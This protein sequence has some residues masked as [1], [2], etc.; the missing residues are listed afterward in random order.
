MQPLTVS[1]VVE[2]LAIDTGE[3]GQFSPEERLPDPADIMVVC[4][5]LISRSAAETDVDKDSDSKVDDTA[6]GFRT[7]EVRLAHFSVKEYLLSQRCAFRSDFTDQACHTII[8][9]GC[10][11]YLLYVSEQAP[12]TSEIVN[13]H[14]LARY[15]AEY[16]WKHAQNIGEAGGNVVLDLALK[17]LTSGHDVLF[18]WLQL[19]D[20]DRP[21]LLF[22]ASPKPEEVAQPLYYAAHCGYLK[23]VQRMVQWNVDSDARGGTGG[24]ALHPALKNYSGKMVPILLDGG[25][26]VNAQ[27][28][29]YGF[30]LQVASRNGREKLVQLFLEIGADVNA[31]GGI[32]GNALQAASFNGHEKVVKML[33]DAGADV[34]A[35]GGKFS[36]ALLA[37]WLKGRKTVLQILTDAGADVYADEHL[38][39][40]LRMAAGRRVETVEIVQAWLDAGAPRI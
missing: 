24:P 27:G 19:Y 34:N 9:E 4:S 14:P 38:G 33:L 36:S 28:G 2:I 15:A 35:Q 10:L 31:Q 5:S 26:G 6:E 17:V 39:S 7:A 30:P 23:L 20:P 21:L 22:D 25:A 16:W 1:E 18:S 37:A 12:L 32:Y 3:D 29:R 40:A 11:R 13:Q 8:A